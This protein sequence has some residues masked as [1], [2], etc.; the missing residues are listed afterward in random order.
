MSAKARGSDRSIS[1]AF[2]P[3]WIRL[4]L[5]LPGAILFGAAG[6]FLEFDGTCW[7]GGH[8][9]VAYSPL[10]VAI[11]NVMSWPIFVFQALGFSGSGVAYSYD[12]LIRKYWWL[13]VPILW[14]YY[15]LLLTLATAAMTS[16]RSLWD[17]A[18]SVS[19]R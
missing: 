6:I 4:G 3:H 10:K 5:A 17:R 19:K 16:I 7:F 15:Y 18:R 8:D 13:L 14:F 9:C 12:P 1:R 11:A 2:R